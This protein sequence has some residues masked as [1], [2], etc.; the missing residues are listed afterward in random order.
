M[1]QN[2]LPRRL[3]MTLCIVAISLTVSSLT[4]CSL[5][6]MAGKM[7]FGDP[8]IAS[9]FT[10]RTGIDLTKDQKKLLVICHTPY[11]VE[12]AMPLLMSSAWQT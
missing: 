9:T 2:K 1:P 6:V 5:F 11:M 3:Q 10:D 4:G 12:N 7:L 8:K